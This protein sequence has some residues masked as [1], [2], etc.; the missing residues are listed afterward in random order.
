MTSPPLD[1]LPFCVPST[2]R[3]EPGASWVYAGRGQ[4]IISEGIDG[5]TEP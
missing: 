1:V 3:M 5:E 2:L 4:K